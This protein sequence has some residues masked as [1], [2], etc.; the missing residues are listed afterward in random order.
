MKV[1]AIV[2]DLDGYEEHIETL[3]SS[4]EI[5]LKY[6]RDGNNYRECTLI[7]WELDTQKRKIVERGSL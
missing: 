4:K 2:Y 1:Y 3:F 6:W 7:T 5:A